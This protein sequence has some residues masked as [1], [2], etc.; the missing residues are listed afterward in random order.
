MKKR[1]LT[2]FSID[3]RKFVISGTYEICENQDYNLEEYKY[4][5]FSELEA[6]NLVE[7]ELTDFTPEGETWTGRKYEV[8]DMIQSVMAHLILNSK[9]YQIE[10]LDDGLKDI[11][12]EYHKDIALNINELDI[13]RK[14]LYLDMYNLFEL[15]L[16]TN[17]YIYYSCYDQMLM[18]R[19]DTHEI[20]SDNYF[21]SVGFDDSCKNVKTGK[22]VLLWG[23]I[24]QNNDCIGGF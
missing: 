9:V 4:P 14:I 24:Q 15:T 5:E 12:D 1:I 23:T 8:S 19:T 2:K 18:F 10:Y 17:E 20:V 3:D 22:E 7:S 6:Q 11:I 21:A 13:P 16:V